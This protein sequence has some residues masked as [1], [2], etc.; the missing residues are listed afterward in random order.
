MDFFNPSLALRAS[1][2]D[3]SL[4]GR[5]VYRDRHG[6][7]TLVDVAIQCQTDWLDPQ[8]PSALGMTV[9]GLPGEGCYHLRQCAAHAP[10]QSMR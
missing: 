10:N 3:L 2:V 8:A 1:A 4:K 9:C 7:S 6:E 5:G